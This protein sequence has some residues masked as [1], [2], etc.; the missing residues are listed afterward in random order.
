MRVTVAVA[1]ALFSIAG[2][3]VASDAD[4]AIRR[5][6]HIQAQEL[7]SA[8]QTL[9][10]DRNL[11]VIYGYEVVGDRRTAGADGDLTFDEALSQILAGTGLAFRYLDDKTVTILPAAAASA[12][13][14]NSA[15][16]SP[17]VPSGKAQRSFPGDFR[18]AQLDHPAN[19]GDGSLEPSEDTD[20]KLPQLEEVVVTGTHIRGAQT[21]STVISVT[22]EEMRNAGENTLTDVIRDLPQNSGGGENPGVGIGVHGS[23]N[24]S[25]AS[26]INLRGLGGD[27]TLT[28]LNGHR[29][30]YNVDRQSIDVSSIPIAAVDRMEVVADG[31]SALYGSDAVGGVVNIILKPDYNG[32]STSARF[33]G[34][35][36]GGD[37][38][39]QYTAVGG[40]TWTSGGFL[41]AYEYEGDSDIESRDRSYAADLSPGLVL[42]PKLKHQSVLF[43]VHQDLSPSVKLSMDA[44]YNNRSNHQVY[45]L[46]NTGNVFENGG[47]FFSN[48][49]SFAV[50]PALEVSLP[51]DWQI[52]VS[53]MYGQDRS[54]I[55]EVA[56]SGGVNA[57]EVDDCFCNRAW[58]VEAGADGALFR[59]PAGEVRMALGGGYR[60]NSFDL[61]DPGSPQLAIRSTQGTS[62]QYAELNFPIVSAQQSIPAI[63]GLTFSGAVR[64]EAY[65]GIDSVATP[66]LGLIYSPSEDFDIKGSWGRSFKAPTLNERYY[67]TGNVIY[68]AS[69][70]GGVG[71]PPD[72]TAMFLSGGNQN[73]RPEHAKTWTTTLVAHPRALEGSRL[74]V[75][76]FDI[77]YTDRVVSPIPY[78]Y[79]ALT[80]PAYRDFVTFNPTDAQKTAA[81][82]VG[83]IYPMTGVPY[84][85]S[86]VVAI[87]D[88]RNYNA[89]VQSIRG[90]DALAQY[91]I[92]LAR[93]GSLTLSGNASYLH[94][95]QQLSR[96]EPLTELA[97]TIFNPP[98]VRGRLGVAWNQSRLT[99]ASFVSYIGGVEDV[100]TEQVYHVGSMTTVDLTARYEFPNVSTFLRDIDLTAS[101]QN[102]FNV[103][104]HNIAQTAVY[105]TPYD[106]TNYSPLG[107]FISFG[108]AKKW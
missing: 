62:F 27:A 93:A 5:Q 41:T 32:V 103:E 97:G 71:Y 107:R 53:G 12:E 105:E 29:L 78:Y 34:S 6:T 101:I 23:Q 20:R 84:D 31:A 102:L 48:D 99:L 75:S 77:H 58:S 57:Y 98:H 26:T 47:G 2:T 19:P 87:A 92:Q 44:L 72:A 74:E 104:P 22:Q 36:Q 86:T 66:K 37:R 9:A 13:P 1:V 18:V 8:L 88:D 90:L 82:A 56:Y 61:V 25:G 28:L 63:R 76:Y 24:Y 49:E 81:E 73:L 11:Q 30:A 17:I 83:Q 33:G 38:Q 7:D 54:Q 14:D 68:K 108:I 55:T 52:T 79:Q 95:T 10:R 45:P 39:Q 42:Y 15:D 35:T 85:P 67:S 21:A 59:V 50:A 16:S 43:S 51:H 64:R 91:R 69:D 60:S 46:D 3:S 100:R 80:N 106:S 96:L 89:A 40:K 65:P 4:A 70:L 94:S